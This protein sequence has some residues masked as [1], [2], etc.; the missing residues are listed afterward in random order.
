MTRSRAQ[1]RSL[2]LEDISRPPS[3]TRSFWSFNE[4]EE[5]IE[6]QRVG[7]RASRRKH[8]RRSRRLWLRLVLTETSILHS[9][10]ARIVNTLIVCWLLRSILLPPITHTHTHTHFP[11]PSL[12]LFTHSAHFHDI[13]LGTGHWANQTWA[14]TLALTRNDH[15]T[16]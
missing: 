1:Y 5:E 8:K 11:F 7:E 16:N 6:R 12:F 4:R 2:A 15:E 13:A 9:N 10:G 14:R 3:F